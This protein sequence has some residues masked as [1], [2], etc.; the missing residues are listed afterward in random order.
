MKITKHHYKRYFYLR[1]VTTHHWTFTIEHN[2]VGYN[3]EIEYNRYTSNLIDENADFDGYFVG[4]LWNPEIRARYKHSY[5]SFGYS[6]VRNKVKY[7]LED[8]KRVIEGDFSNVIGYG[9][10]KRDISNLK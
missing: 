8:M 2:G 4:Y 3:G 6:D 5:I 1:R 10:Y 9:S 7:I